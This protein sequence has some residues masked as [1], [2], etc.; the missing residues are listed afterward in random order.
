MTVIRNP[1]LLMQELNRLPENE[2]RNFLY[3]Q[4]FNDDQITDF[5]AS[6]KRDRVVLV[7]SEPK[8]VVPIAQDPAWQSIQERA[9][10]LRR[11]AVA[12]PPSSLRGDG[13]TPLELDIYH[14]RYLQEGSTEFDQASMH[15]PTLKSTQTLQWLRYEFQGGCYRCGVIFGDHGAGK[16]WSALAWMNS[17]ASYEVKLFN[18]IQSNMA[19]V[20]AY[21]LSEMVH[22]AKEWKNT[23]ER[24]RTVEWLLL[25]DLGTE[26]RGFRGDNF[27]AFLDNLISY[28]HKFR[29]CKTLIT[30]NATPEQFKAIY[31]DRIVSRIN[32]IGIYKE[33]TDID[34][35]A[36]K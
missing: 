31:G 14:N 25:D 10:I 36:A 7:K 12:N 6:M 34:Y 22:N 8:K 18:V 9:E 4:G 3:L 30:T 23:L 35:R 11:N 26:P 15:H 13:L 32:D 29:R 19:F 17:Q 27:I 1:V 2:H 33:V 16:T 21:R 28:R 24:L 5:L 20:D